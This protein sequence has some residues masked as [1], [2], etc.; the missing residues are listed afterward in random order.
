MSQAQIDRF[1]AEC[2]VAVVTGEARERFLAGG[3]VRILFV[4]GDVT[5]R[6]EVGDL[7][8]VLREI[9]RDYA[10]RVRV[11]LAARDEE[12][13]F[14]DSFGIKV[15]PTMVVFRDGRPMGVIPGMKRW[16]EY[17]DMVRRL[18]GEVADGEPEINPFLEVMMET[19]R[20]ASF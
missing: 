9:L 3:G 10:D 12:R 19:R 6:P 7:T 11:A 13:L 1:M 20:F 15:L 14:R 16:E 2:R 17:T 18:L 5:K 4:T 8:V